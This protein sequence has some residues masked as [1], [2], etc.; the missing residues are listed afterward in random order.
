MVRKLL[1]FLMVKLLRMGKVFHAYGGSDVAFT[2][3]IEASGKAG[4]GCYLILKVEDLYQV[5][6]W[7]RSD[8]TL[9]EQEALGRTWA[10]ERGLRV[11]FVRY[12]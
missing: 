9:S 4:F 6:C 2:C 8:K 1:D 12:L 10:R 3:F 7:A 11:Q 5:P